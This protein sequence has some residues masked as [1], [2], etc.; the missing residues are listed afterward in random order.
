MN[1]SS[2]TLESNGLIMDRTM[3]EIQIS[4]NDMTTT[5]ERSP[6]LVPNIPK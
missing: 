2:N 1:E 4:G 3:I 6:D 5:L